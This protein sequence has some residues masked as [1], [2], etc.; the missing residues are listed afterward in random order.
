[1]NKNNHYLLLSIILMVACITSFSSDIY[2]PALIVIS[3]TLPSATLY[4]TQFSVIIFMITLALSQLVFGPLSE[5]FGRKKPMLLGSV[6]LLMGTVVCMLSMHINELVIGRAIQ[7]VGAGALAAL[8]RSVFRDALSGE[9]LAKSSA[10]I[11]VF[12]VFI[13]AIAPSLGGYLTEFNWRYNFV[14]LFV[15]A[16]IVVLI[17]ALLYKE[18][19]MTHHKD[20]LSWQYAM[21]QYG[22]LLKSPVFMGISACTFLMYGTLF[23]WVT[24]APVLLIHGLSLA[25]STFG[26]I[27][28]VL[29]GSMYIFATFC[30]VRGVNRFGMKSMMRLGFALVFVSGV[31]MAILFAVNGFDLF[32]ILIPAALLYFGSTFIWSNAFSRAFTPFGDIAG[33]AGSLYGFMQILGGGLIALVATHLPNHNQLTFGIVIVAMSLAA[34]VLHEGLVNAHE[35]KA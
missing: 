7:G 10:Y 33:Y 1:M 20:H 30:N 24:I 25:P 22:R 14:A 27:I 4:L 6:I 35:Q 26:W 8:W 13:T 32:S 34:M 17:L 2:T 5:V 23:A 3:R 15:Y 16:V 12:I 31:L 29:G 19:S 21:T 28:A 9:A 11:S 18:T